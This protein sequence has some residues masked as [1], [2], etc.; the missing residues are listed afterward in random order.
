M[1]KRVRHDHAFVSGIKTGGRF[2]LIVCPE[3]TCRKV[4]ILGKE[5]PRKNGCFG[6]SK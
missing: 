6:G 5:P 4:I 1:A 3:P 2:Q